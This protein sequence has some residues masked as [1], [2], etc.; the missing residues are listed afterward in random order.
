MMTVL[1]SI[2]FIGCGN[3]GAAMAAA[4]DRHLPLATIIALDRDVEG[5]RRR[6]PAKTRIAIKAALAADAA[7]RPDLAVLAVKPQQLGDA[8]DGLSDRLS[9]TLVMSVAAGVTLNEL[10]RRLPQS[11]VVRTMP[12]LAS[13]VG[14]GMT[15]AV[16]GAA[17]SAADREQIET[18]CGTFGR[19]RWLASEAEIDAATAVS[20]SGPGYLF[21]IADMLARA[22]ESAGLPPQIADELARQT[23]VGTGRLLDLDPRTAAELKRAVSSPG[24]T[25]EAGL[26]VLEHRPGLADIM[27]QAVR[28][29]TVRAQALARDHG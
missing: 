19:F 14:A 23:I 20:G 27:V 1:T 4:V 21:A 17:L 16:A 24:G 8:L 12:N 26:A 15:V 25:T 9:G 7:H 2:L 22:G 13:M 3:L 11:R 28:A 5:S 6:L 18:V 29:A 10:Q